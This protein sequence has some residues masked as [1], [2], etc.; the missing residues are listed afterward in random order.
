MITEIAN[1]GKDGSLM[2]AANGI[3]K[4]TFKLDDRNRV[5]EV[6]HYGSDEALK[7]KNNPNLELDKALSS[8]SAGA[9]TRYTY[10]G[11]TDRVIKISF[12]GKD[13]Q[14]EG[15]KAWGN[16][17]S[18]EMRYT[19]EGWISSIASFATDDT[20]IALSKELFGDN[21]VKLGMEHDEFGNLSK[22]IFYG[23]ED[24]PVTS[25]TL[26]AAECRYKYDDKRRQTGQ[27]Y[28]GTG[29]D[30]IE[31]NDAAKGFKYHGFTYEYNDDDERTLVIYYDTTANEVRR[32]NLTTHS[33]EV[34]SGKSSN[35]S[36]NNSSEAQPV[37]QNNPPK[38]S[39]SRHPAI[40]TLMDFH[41]N[42]TNRNFRAA[43]SCLSPEMQNHM[44]YD[45]W[46]DGFNTTV[47]SSVSDF[48]VVSEG[49]GY[50]VLEYILTAVDNPG[51]T[52]RFRGTATV[53]ET[54]GGWKI[55]TVKN[56]AL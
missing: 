3:A 40:Q 46:I 20:P 32:Q 9:I 38:V 31:I 16:I 50:V 36:A 17:A 43:Y 19:P 44:G 52:R 54:P 26:G 25:A 47:S 33:S 56:K 8:L 2:V 22:T 14:A 5:V 28:Y 21:V 15:I 27:E 41:A 18:L 45:S 4:T 48:V 37:S 55:D 24:N 23:K 29:G 35:L 1:Y 51:G 39:N 7:D 11:N 13:E 49:G 42:I 6:R 10:D 12:L 53:I 34:D 30:K